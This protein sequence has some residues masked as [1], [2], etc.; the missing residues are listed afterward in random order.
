META[1]KFASEAE[2][3]NSLCGLP[4]AEI[5]GL[6]RAGF[7]PYLSY[8]VKAF[9]TTLTQGAQNVRSGGSSEF[10]PLQ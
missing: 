3:M 6:L 7:L 4:E 10:T 1:D 8:G 2:G 9:G 5:Y